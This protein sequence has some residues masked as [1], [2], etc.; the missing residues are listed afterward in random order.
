MTSKKNTQIIFNKRP[1]GVPDKDCF[2]IEE[3]DIPEL[4]EGQVLVE[5]HYLSVDP[6]MRGR[7]NDRKSY[8]APFQVGEVLTGGAVG[9][10]VAS[11]DQALKEGDY[12]MGMM[13][14]ENFAAVAAKGLT[15]VNP[16][17]AP[18][19]TSLGILGMPGL[20]AYFG[21]LEIGKPKEKETVVVSGAAGAVGTIVGQIAKIKGCRV[22][23][24]A[25][26]D[27]KIDYLKNELGFDEGINYKTSQNLRADLKA[28]C[29]NGVDVYFENV[30]G[31][32]SDAVITLINNHARIPLCGQIADYNSTE[33]PVGPRW[34]S[35]LLTRMALLQGFLVGQFSDKYGEGIKQLAA[36]LKEG[37]LKN[38]ENIVEGIEQT[39]DA[40]LGLFKGENIGKQLVKIK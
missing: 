7:M 15:K 10:I 32:I 28:A 19:S 34:Q 13:G 31:E 23:G 3:T 33:M 6:Y 25:G 16:D 14:W 35:Y 30:G 2:R 9:K 18:I 17:L 22:V 27:E 8:I 29:P 36:W 1:V 5:V 37:K 21:L 26:S 39:P 11:K 38:K 20:T 4:L 40:F 24:I 12:V